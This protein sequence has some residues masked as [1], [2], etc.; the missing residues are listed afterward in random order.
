MKDNKVYVE[1]IVTHPCLV[2]PCPKG[3]YNYYINFNDSHM[4]IINDFISSFFANQKETTKT[5][6]R[7]NLNL[8]QIQILDSIIYNSESFL[9]NNS[10]PLNSNKY[11]IITTL[12]EYL[13]GGSY[14]KIYY[15]I[16]LEKREVSK[17][18]F[19]YHYKKQ[20]ESSFTYYTIT[21][22]E[23]LLHETKK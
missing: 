18:N 15:D 8:E 19:F 7:E 5:I 10:Y 21:I 23:D 13:D 2:S 3:D 6:S 20:K 14:E 9:D 4:K 16:D 1:G 12:N 11:T 22:D 17:N